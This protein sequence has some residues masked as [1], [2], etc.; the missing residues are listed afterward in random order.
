MGYHYKQSNQN[1][2]PY[3]VNKP[4]QNE[5]NSKKPLRSPIDFESQRICPSCGKVLNVHHNFCK[6][7]GVDLSAI[8]S[9]SQ[10]DRTLKELATMSLTDPNAE[11]R[12][13]AVAALGEFEELEA[14]GVLTHIL[15]NDPHPI[16]RKQ[17]AH[18]LGVLHHPLS[19]D[20]LAKALRDKA[21]SV[22]KEAIDGLKMIKLKSKQKEVP[23]NPEVVDESLDDEPEEIVEEVM[24]EPVAEPVE[25]EEED[26]G[27]EEDKKE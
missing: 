23:V 21:P 19:L 24:E 7:C 8:K 1:D 20:V 16:V 15:I 27:V 10:S 18:E 2:N 25:A 3:R 14:L 5:Q 9:L 26:P 6:F 13:N 12:A 17:A 22:R 11:V 4:V